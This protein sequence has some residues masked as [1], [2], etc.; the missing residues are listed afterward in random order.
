MPAA[1]RPRPVAID[2]DPGIDDALAVPP[3]AGVDHQLVV[4][5]PAVLRIQRVDLVLRRC[6]ERGHRRVRHCRVRRGPVEVP[7]NRLGRIHRI[8]EHIDL[9][10][11]GHALDHLRFFGF[12]LDARLELV[13]VHEAH[14]RACVMLAVEVL[15]LDQAEAAGLEEVVIR[16]AVLNRVSAS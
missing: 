13:V 8:G 4:D 14:R 1:A 11:A 16:V 10:S 7:V 12:V 6:D 5:R 2:T 15:V 3:H 9:L